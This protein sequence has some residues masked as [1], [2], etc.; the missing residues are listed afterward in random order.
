MVI[1]VGFWVLG[2]AVVVVGLVVVGLV[3]VG[4][5]AVGLVAGLVAGLEAV[6]VVV[7]VT[8]LV[9]F[10]E[11]VLIGIPKG[12]LAGAVGFGASLGLESTNTGAALTTG[13]ECLVG[14]A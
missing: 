11:L 3:A 1:V 8:D 13:T 4:L 2:A 10:E 14:A 12:F 6:E 9:E 7:L 5:V